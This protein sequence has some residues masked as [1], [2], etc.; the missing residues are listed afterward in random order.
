MAP[1]AYPSAPTVAGWYAFPYQ[2]G[3]LSWYWDG[4]RWTGEARHGKRDTNVKSLRT[5][6]AI[7]TWGW[8][9]IAALAVVMIVVIAIDG[10]VWSV[11]PF[12]L[13]LGIGLVGV[14]WSRKQAAK[15]REATPAELR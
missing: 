9:F 13:H 15:L 14:I 2:G 7:M 11:T 5:R 6:I 10:A 3:E 4:A 1:T 12:L 8:V